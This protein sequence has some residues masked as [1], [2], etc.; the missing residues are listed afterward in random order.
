M[1]AN[2]STA[3]PH[4]EHSLALRWSLTNEEANVSERRQLSSLTTGSSPRDLA[5]ASTERSH[6]QRRAS[7]SDIGDVKVGSLEMM[8]LMII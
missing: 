8:P 2:L 3:L 6:C 4:L 1:E 5:E 7:L